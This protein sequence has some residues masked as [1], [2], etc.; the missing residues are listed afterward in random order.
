MAAMLLFHII[1]QISLAIYSVS[2]HVASSNADLLEQK[3]VF[4]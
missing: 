4:T 1:M 3:K 2:G